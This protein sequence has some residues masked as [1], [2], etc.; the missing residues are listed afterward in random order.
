MTDEDVLSGDW[1]KFEDWIREKIGSDFVWKI[2]PLDKESNRQAVMESIVRLLSEHNCSCR[3]EGQMFIEPEN[4]Q[5]A[6]PEGQT[7]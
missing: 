2:R 4:S 3:E 5:P 6:S 7:S 1:K